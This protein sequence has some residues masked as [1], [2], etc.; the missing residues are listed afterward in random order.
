M[1]S[2]HQHALIADS[3]STKTTWQ[4]VRADG[5]AKSPFTTDGL[6]PVYFSDSTALVT[7]L[8][9]EVLPQLYGTAINV[10]Y[11]YGAGCTG[12]GAERMTTALQTVFPKATIAVASDLLGA[13][14]SLLGHTAGIAC[15][16]GTGSNSCLYNGY[17][18]TANISPLGYIL[19]DEGSG[20]VLGKRLLA[21]VL[22]C[23]AP[24]SIC[25][26]FAKQYDTDATM[27]I[28]RVYR[29][30]HPNRF[31]AQF[32][33]F[34]NAHLTD[35]YVQELLHDCFCDFLRRNVRQYADYE[36]L[37][38]TFTGSVAA[39]FE[40]QLRQAAADCALHITRITQ[41]PLP[42]L[43]AFHQQTMGNERSI[44]VK[45]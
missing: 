9:A 5:G 14:R 19:G 18:I 32:T 29:Q 20:A 42:N 44:N 40:T 2:T 15:I 38:L 4:C 23:Q 11:F 6:N 43:I 8:N 10:V 45:L 31:L 27:I 25:A 22:K 21:D 26:A 16:L 7:L 3:G 24:Q 30:P 41:D 12:T 17:N 37:P 39:V 36:R 35:T 28:D 1:P 33:H 34:L 13:A